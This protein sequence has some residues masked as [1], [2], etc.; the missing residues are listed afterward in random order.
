[1]KKLNPVITTCPVC[2]HDLHITHLEC[3]HCNTKISGEFNFSKFNYLDQE[4]LLFIELFVKNRGNI[5]A[6]EKEMNVSYPTVKR[7][8]EEAIVA[9][10]YKVDEDDED[11]EE[12]IVE[13]KKSKLAEAQ[14]R[15]AEAKAKK[16]EILDKIKGGQLKVEDAIEQIKKLKEN[17]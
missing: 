7:H 4:T 6:V 13:L 2:E 11:E 14:S 3:E 10:G 12:D 15:I 17:K 9:L 16:L 8:L 5:K 1:M